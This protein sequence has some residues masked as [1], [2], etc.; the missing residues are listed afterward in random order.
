M[1]G[2]LIKRLVDL[3]NRGPKDDYFYPERS[4]ITVF[5]RS[6]STYHNV[7]PEIR[8]IGYRG[9]AAWGGRITIPLTRQNSGDLLQ[10]LAIRIQPVSFWGATIDT[11]LAAGWTFADVSGQ[12]RWADS[13]ATAAIARVELEIGDALVETWPGEW[14]DIWS[15]TWMDAS[16]AGTWD[17]DIYGY[18]VDGTGTGS[19]GF[20]C[21]LPLAM[22]RRV[23]TAFPL[24]AVTTQEIRVNVTFRPF[25]D[26]V[27]MVDRDRTGPCQVPLGSTVEL[28]SPT[29]VIQSFTVPVVQP[30]FRMSILAGVSLTEGELRTRYMKGSLELLYEPVTYSRFDMPIALAAGPIPC[31]V[32][33]QFPLLDLNGP[34]RELAFVLRRKDVWKRAAWT[35]YSRTGA[36]DSGITNSILVSARLWVDNAVWRNE[37]EE[38][39]RVEYGLSHRGGVRL[40]AGFV[41]G[42]VFGGAAGAEDLQPGATVNATRSDLRLELTM[43]A[44]DS[45]EG[46]ELH[47]FAVGL[48]WMR[49]SSGMAVPL[50][51][52]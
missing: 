52:D 47:V 42:I 6:T 28:R 38:W 22:L 10:W 11:Q 40:A 43:R 19:D 18:G 9:T 25:H 39:W 13:L 5:Q 50:F 16:R 37:L 12:W 1:Q 15:R 4:D 51:R 29:G 30:G 36:D 7:V 46:W 49:F 34:I 24:A 3:V 41:Y 23:S 2:P 33:A 27:R 32:T 31:T 17:T 8:E 48:N 26:V 21:W 14:M 44:P 45:T 35:D 20:Y